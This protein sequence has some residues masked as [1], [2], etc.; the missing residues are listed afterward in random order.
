PPARRQ[1]AGVRETRL[2][3]RAVWPRSD[4][5]HETL[6]H[7]IGRPAAAGD[8]RRVGRP[9]WSLLGVRVERRSAA[10]RRT[11]PGRLGSSDAGVRLQP[12]QERAPAEG[13]TG[14]E[15]RWAWDLERALT[16]WL[17]ERRSTS[18]KLP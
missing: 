13:A 5:L 12:S 16:C 6:R 14:R 18:P 17:S 1:F 10:Q 8:R 7:A 2:A 3:C 9:A 15:A 4:R 11:C